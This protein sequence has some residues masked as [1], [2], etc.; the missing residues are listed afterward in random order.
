MIAEPAKQLM[1]SHRARIT[2]TVKDFLG[3]PAV[4]TLGF[5]CRG[6]E[7]NSLVRERRSSMP[8]CMD[9]K[10]TK[11]LP[12]LWCGDKRVPWDG[13]TP[14]IPSGPHVKQHTG[15]PLRNSGGGAL[16]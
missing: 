16:P 3:N 1:T 2:Q 5:H 7:L 14:E 11:K 9:K 8:Y 15:E 13:R 10:L 6:S 4:E 12:S